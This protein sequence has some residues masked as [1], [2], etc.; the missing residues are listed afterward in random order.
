M[1]HESHSLLRC[2]DLLQG[3]AL[4]KRPANR[5]QNHRYWARWVG[6]GS[7]RAGT[8][9][10]RNAFAKLGAPED[11]VGVA[12]GATDSIVIK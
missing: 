9:A 12:D 3:V 6:H 11:A 4:M 10:S 5:C 2:W 7:D 1:F 8:R